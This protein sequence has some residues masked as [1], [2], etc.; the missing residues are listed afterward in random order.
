MSNTSNFREAI[1]RAR[2][3]S[4]VGPQVIA[5]ALPFVGGGLILQRFS[6]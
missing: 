2:G 5:K 6:D 3:Q 1:D 4:L